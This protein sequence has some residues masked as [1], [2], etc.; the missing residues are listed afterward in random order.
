MSEE[1]KQ[2]LT[3]SLGHSP[4][5]GKLVEALSKAR[6]D[7]H[8]VK[9]ESEN[10]Y[11]KSSYAD[12]ATLIEATHEGLSKNGLVVIQS[13][14]RLS[15]ANRIEITT[16]LAHSSG[17][18]LS[19]VLEM[20]VTKVDAQGLGS[21]IT[22]GRR[23][24]YQAILN[25]AG[26]V[27]DDGNA[28]V[29]R[30]QKDRQSSSTDMSEKDGRSINPAQQRAFWAAA[31]KGGKSKDT[32]LRKLGEIGVERTDEILKKDFDSMLKWALDTSDSQETSIKE[33]F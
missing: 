3:Q 4:T 27:D 31:T 1:V 21:A 18:S 2:E 17:E 32:V 20:P 10:P 5:I 6:A 29:G 25:V 33:P 13:P 15:E 9:K 12:L 28:A 22:Y 11:F 16:I 8:P 30:S 26:D 23:Y 19:S 14:G 24:A 7:F